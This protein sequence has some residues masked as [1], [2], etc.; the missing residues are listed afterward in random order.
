MD[1]P[2]Y[3]TGLRWGAKGDGM[4]FADALARGRVTAGGR[5]FPVPGGMIE[6]AENLRREYKIGRQE[7]DEFSACIVTTAAIARELGLTP[8]AR[9][10]TWSIGGVAPNRM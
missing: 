5:N 4:N 6:T 9:R 10:V 8:L 1:A 3:A 2:F 7:Q